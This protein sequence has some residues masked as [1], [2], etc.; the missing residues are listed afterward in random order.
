[1]KFRIYSRNKFEYYAANVSKV[2]KNKL[3]LRSI[4]NNVYLKKII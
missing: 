1:M 3:V 4:A 2:L